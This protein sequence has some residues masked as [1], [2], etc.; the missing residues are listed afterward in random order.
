MVSRR[1]A[2]LGMVSC[3]VFSFVFLSLNHYTSNLESSGKAS[4]DYHDESSKLVEKSSVANVAA[5][6]INNSAMVWEWVSNVG[7]FYNSVYVSDIAIGS[8]NSIYLT[9][10]FI[11]EVYFSDSVS[12]NSQ[13]QT[14]FVAKLSSDG[15]WQWAKKVNSSSES[16]IGW[17]N[18]LT[19]DSNDNVYVTGQFVDYGIF[20]TT[21][22]TG[23]G[24]WNIFVAKLNS[25]GEWQW[26]KKASGD[27][28]EVGESIVVDSN[29]SIYLTGYT[30]S[31]TTFF[32]NFSINGSGYFVTYIAKL[33]SDG[34]WQWVQTVA[35]STFSYSSIT[36]DSNDSLLVTGSFSGNLNLGDISLSSESNELLVAKL[37][38]SGSWQ[39]AVKAGGVN[40]ETITGISTGLADEIYV[41]GTFEG[42][43]TFGN[44]TLVSVGDFDIFVAKLDP[45]GTWASAV[46]AGG[47]LEDYAR[48]ISVDS[49]GNVYISGRFDESST[50]GEKT[51]QSTGDNNT[52]IAKLDANETWQEVLSLESGQY[53]DGHGV[54]V[55]SDQD[56]IVYI[57]GEFKGVVSFGDRNYLSQ[58]ASDFYIAKLTVDSDGD[59]YSDRLDKC[60]GYNDDID[61]DGDD[62]PD[63]CDP[64]FDQNQLDET[65]NAEQSSRTGFLDRLL[66]GDLDAIGIILAISLPVIGLSI[67]IIIR[68]KRISIVN[69]I[70]S[71][72][73]QAD[74]LEEL[75][76]ISQQIEYIIANDKISL[77][78]Y[79]SLTNRIERRSK[80]LGSTKTMDD[81]A[82]NPVGN[83]IG[84]KSI[85]QSSSVHDSVVSGDAYVGSTKINNQ[86]FNDPE[87]I[88]RAA[89]E[90]YKLG[91]V[92]A[93]QIATEQD[94][95]ELDDPAR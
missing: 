61:S 90:A 44:I 7:S 77:V 52:F 28:I 60:T 10:R 64:V 71:K 78:Q 59:G 4:D 56:A 93:K 12:I 84:T 72:I 5:R 54:K 91:T 67:S 75:E 47:S 35:F 17:G 14:I 57:T 31:D 19:L 29:G 18:S 69:Y 11:G 49:F 22:L 73:Y 82:T 41:T 92:D 53:L 39:W 66:E 81:D 26:A 76:L 46:S 70:T 20:G 2:A 6:E 21:N 50:F 68:R 1:L 62:I 95:E 24:S 58:G 86:I 42:S 85:H 36:V 65:D 55:N 87:V 83:D 32:D 89:V 48:G 33:N 30:L 40:I 25:D 74:S 51:V 80:S 43:A 9:G 8:D 37:S 23:S 38:S 45:N 3:V 16:I 34:E 15:I 63:G 88:A 94:D 79:Q 13:G 27:Y